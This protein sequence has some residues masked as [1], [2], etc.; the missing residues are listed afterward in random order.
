[1]SQG[2]LPVSKATP[3]WICFIAENKS[4]EKEGMQME[5]RYEI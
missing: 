4:N 1:M 3:Y 2:N 5:H